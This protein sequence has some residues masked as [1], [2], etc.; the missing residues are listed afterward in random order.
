V[1]TDRAIDQAF[2]DL[3][4][5]CGGV[6]NDCFALLYLEQEFSLDRDRA[7]AQVAW[8]G[9]DYGVDGFHFDGAK[10]NL[11]LFQFKWSDS[12]AQFKQTFTRLIDAGMERIFGA[13]G[14]DQEQNQLLLQLKSCLI[15]N[16]A[17]IDR[18]LIHFVFKG[19]PDEAERSKVLEMLREQLENKKYLLDQRFGRPITLVVEFRSARTH[20][21]GTTAH[22]RKT[23]TYP[24]QLD[25]TVDRAGPNGE[26][27]TIGFIRL[28]DLQSIYSEMRDRFFER[29]IRAALP[30]DKAVNRAIQRSL[31]RIVLDDKDNALVFAFNHNGVTLFAEALHDGGSD[32]QF[33]ITEPRLLNGAQ[34]VT[35]FAR[36]LKAN[37]GNLSLA[38]RRAT[39]EKIRVM[40]RI[41]TGAAPEFVTTVTLN[42]NRQNPVNPWNLRANDRIQLELQDKFR[43][44]LEIYYERQE[45][46]F[47]GLSDEE[48]E[49]QGIT[50][51]KAIELPRLARTFLVSDGEIDKLSRF[52]EVFEDD[53]VYETVFSQGRL[54]ADSRKIILA[55]KVQFRLGRLVGDIVD[56]GANKY[57]YV[58]RARNLL[59]A[60]LCQGM[61]NDPNL[62][63]RAEQFGRGLSLEAQF[64]DWLS[65]LATTRC[66]FIMSDLVADRAYATRAAEGRFDFIRTNAAYKRSMEIAYGRWRWVEKHLTK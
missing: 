64:T 32:G 34:T 47:E 62:E 33:K 39:L 38:E 26:K 50:H 44:D 20:K 48:L 46:A 56:K 12:H 65:T 35:T 53:K 16:E 54:R 58:Q 59:W 57:A 51:H 4:S 22:L 31:K 45:K 30:E 13:Q 55:Y 37:D 49:A 29:N 10:R 19:D 40:C 17:V 21:V 27:M 5:T 15:E 8:G 2:S 3:R 41:I 42:N 60:L 1:I 24:I 23:H 61:L 66:R 63:A 25:T 18:V 11:Y 36:F 9:N 6:R 7:M 52:R 14:Q 43:D 28:I